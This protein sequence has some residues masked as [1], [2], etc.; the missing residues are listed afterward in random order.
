[1]EPFILALWQTTYTHPEAGTSEALRQ[2]D[3]IAAQA[4]AQS[5]ELLICPEMSLTGY[6]IGPERVAALAETADGPLAQAVSSMAQRHR[7]T[8]VYGYAEQHP[9]GGKPFNA[10]QAI[11]ADG[12]RI[13]HCRK[14]HLFG[15]MDRAQFSAGDVPS[16]VFV[17]RGWRLGLLICYDVEFPESVRALALQGVD[18]V[19]VPTANMLGY[20]EVST[21]LIPARAYEN[22][23]ALAYANACGDE[24][25][26]SY[27]GLST[28]VQANGTVLAL[29]GREAALIC[30]K[31]GRAHV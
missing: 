6:A 15:D 31:I 12:Q 26:L 18:A 27:G 14:T 4:R 10:V 29:A 13:G 23:L 25:V 16:Q 20:D 22:R 17:W 5:A 8:I 21:L 2:L 9:E 7:L 3:A 24:G 28:V 30:A 19:L 11:D 1:M